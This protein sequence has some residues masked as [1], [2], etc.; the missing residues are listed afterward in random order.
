MGNPNSGERVIVTNVPCHVIRAAENSSSTP[1]KLAVSLL[2]A[3]FSE[4]EIRCGNCSQPCKVWFIVYGVKQIWLSDI[5]QQLEE[6]SE[7]IC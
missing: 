7:V 1:E 5:F 3:V 2:L 4:E 6:R